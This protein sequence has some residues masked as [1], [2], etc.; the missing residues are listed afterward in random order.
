MSHPYAD[1]R[2]LAALAR[3]GEETM[4]VAAWRTAV[5]VRPVALGGVDGAGAY[6]MA[7]LGGDAEVEQGLGEMARAG[8]ISVVM[9]ADPLLG[10]SSKAL[11]PAFDLARPFKTHYLIE[12]NR[13]APSKHHRA[14]IRRSVSRCVVERVRFA[15]VADAWGRLYAGL[16]A[17]HRITGV[18]AFSADHWRCLAEL[19]GLE[20]FAA[21]VDGEW[22]SMALWFEHDGVAYN[23]LG[24]SSAAGYAAGAGYALYDAAIQ[25]YASRATLNLGGGAGLSDDASD[26]LARF[27][28]GFASGET[29]AWLYGK[30]LDP[31]RYDELSQGRSTAFFPAYRG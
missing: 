19:D 28:R 22:V 11:A 26:G 21:R 30:V 8:L 31:I 23:H 24:A 5:L 27:K 10:P 13:Y 2:Y 15:D 29:S 14:E 25:H 18:A 6:P 12:P 9:V 20:T 3:N 17:R 16:T 1:S 7:V 4:A